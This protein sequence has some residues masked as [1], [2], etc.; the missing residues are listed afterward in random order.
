MT[1]LTHDDLAVLSVNEV[2]EIVHEAIK[3]PWKYSRT[4]VSLV[5]FILA[6]E[7]T[8]LLQD[9]KHQAEEKER[10]KEKITV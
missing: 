1:T 8:A 6:N 5:D 4:R 2:L 3:I 10:G 9:L 7:N